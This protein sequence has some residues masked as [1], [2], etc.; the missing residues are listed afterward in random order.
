[1][2]MSVLL[3]GPYA[4]ALRA[5]SVEVEL[6]GGAPLTAGAVMASLAEQQPKLRAMLRSALLTVNCRYVRPESTV[7]ETDELA[8]VGLVGGG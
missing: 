4:D 2:K 1:M 7:R 6:P 5:S 3:F 8:V